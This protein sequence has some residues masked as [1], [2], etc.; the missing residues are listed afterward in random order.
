LFERALSRYEAVG[1]QHFIAR[2]LIQLGYAALENHDRHVASDR[3][4]AAMHMAA[5]LGDMWSIA[6]GLEAVACECAERAPEAAA[7]LAGAAVGVRE[8]IAMN[9]HPADQIITRRHLDHARSR[10]G[11][12]RFAAAS[13]AGRAMELSAAIATA[14][15]VSSEPER[16]AQRS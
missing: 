8:Q 10:M 9:A 7:K 13:K 1:D 11:G 14:L 15:N 16:E 2:T 5:G 4:A 6:D 12:E 3:I